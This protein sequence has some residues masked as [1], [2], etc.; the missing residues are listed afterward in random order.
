MGAESSPAETA[1]PRRPDVATTPKPSSEERTA[2]RLEPV[3]V[4]AENA[5]TVE[6]I[7]SILGVELGSALE[8]THARL[9]KLSDPA[10]PPKEEQEEAEEGNDEG[11]ARGARKVLWQFAETDYS[12]VFIKTDDEQRITSIT[13]LLRPEKQQPFE[14]IGEPDK[15][16]VR[17]EREIAWDVLRED[18][19]LI[20]VVATGTDG[21]AE[22]ISIFVV[23][24]R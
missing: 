11:A 15:A 13:A 4:R 10:T 8:E 5:R 3:A 9:D 14:T 23:K 17:T 22:R 6:V 20:R 2:P 18:R 12:A 1:R 7:T 21:K 16:P 24:R 19:P